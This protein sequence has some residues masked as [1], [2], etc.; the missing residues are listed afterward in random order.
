MIEEWKAIPETNGKI[1]ISNTGK[2]RS[3]LKGDTILKAQPDKKGYLRV[4]FTIDRQKRT[5]KVHREVAKAFIPNPDRLPQ[6]NHKDGNKD[7]NAVDNLEWVTNQENALHAINNGLWNSF[8]Q[9]ALKENMQRRIPILGFKDGQVY[10]FPSVSCAE[11]YIG[12]KHICAVLKGKRPH[13]KGWTFS[14]EGG[15]A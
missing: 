1:L 15:D 5:I 13:T 6:V 9:G 7:N 10:W 8:I 4:S 14:Y 3:L 2:V 11:E 12:S